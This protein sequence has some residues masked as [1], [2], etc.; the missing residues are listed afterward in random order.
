MVKI[1]F[2][3]IDKITTI[4]NY[5]LIPFV[6]IALY[7]GFVASDRYTSQATFTVM[8]NSASEGGLDIGF[9]GIGNTGGLEDERI[10]KEYIFSYDML[11][12]LDEKVDLMAHYQSG[13]ADLLSRLSH[14]A[15]REDFLEYYT[16]HITVGFDETSGLLVVEVQAFDREYAMLLLQ[17]ILKQTEGV[18]NGISRELALSQS[19]FLEYQLRNAEEQL[20]ECK[21]KLLEFQSAH[22]V[23]SPVLEGES[24]SGIMTKLE[25]SL[26]EEKANLSQ[27]LGYQKSSAPQVV[28]SKERIRAIEK[29]IKQENMRLVGDNEGAVNDLMSE[30]T[31]LQLNLEFAKNSYTATLAAL[32]HA[33]AESTKKIKHLI[34]ISKPSLADEAKYPDREYI[35]VTSLIVLLML[36]GIVRMTITT[37]KEHRD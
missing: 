15:S 6:V 26:S 32:E 20:K 31:N 1:K 13:G 3:T 21:Q 2:E 4:R 14:Y 37:I 30:Y 17:T 8:E 35:L 10:I 28:A 5:V 19:K 29:Q 24:L 22:G 18:V 12:Y 11:G 7:I 34:T 27:L 23:F 16:K 9:L 33:K 36:F 25:S